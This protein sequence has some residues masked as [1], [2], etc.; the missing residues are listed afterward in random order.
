SAIYRDLELLPEHLLFEVARNQ[1]VPRLFQK[2][3]VEL[4]L[5]HGAAKANH[6]DI[7][8]L[9]EEIEKEMAE[10]EE[11]ELVPAAKP[12]TSLDA[13]ELTANTMLPAVAEVLE[14]GKQFRASVTTA[15]IFGPDTV[16]K[17]DDKIQ[18]AYEALSSSTTIHQKD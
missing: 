18:P 12:L 15:T 7:A 10:L 5:K 6:P 9:K 16:Q 14:E 3:A 11:V 13:T 17:V 4:L 2:E 8:H 1:S